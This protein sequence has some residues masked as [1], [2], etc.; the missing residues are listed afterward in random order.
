[1]DAKNFAVNQIWKTRDGTL[2][3]ITEITDEEGVTYPV[4]AQTCGTEDVNYFTSK[5]RYFTGDD[6]QEFH[7][8]LMGHWEDEQEEDDREAMME[9]QRVTDARHFSDQLML[10]LAGNP[11][12]ANF[13][14]IMTPDAIAHY[15]QSLLD[16]RKTLQF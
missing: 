14:D 9:L 2:V 13:P 3:K 1:M 4:T 16:L 10:A 8:D 12:V 11:G 7:M 5:G 15:T 6:A